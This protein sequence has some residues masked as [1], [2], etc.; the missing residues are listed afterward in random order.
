MA[1]WNE[2]GGVC[3]KQQQEVGGVCLKQ[4]QEVWGFV[5]TGGGFVKQ[6]KKNSSFFWQIFFS[7]YTLH[8]K[9]FYRSLFIQK[10]NT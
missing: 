10:W 4:Q 8:M 5:Y 3:L 9:N 1:E 6:N 2:V 7:E